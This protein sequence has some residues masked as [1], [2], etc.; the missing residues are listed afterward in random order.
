MTDVI[1]LIG[2]V[3]DNIGIGIVTGSIWLE[4]ESHKPG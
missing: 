3:I 4:E 2:I 1:G